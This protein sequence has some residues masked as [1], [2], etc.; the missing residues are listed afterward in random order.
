MNRDLYFTT[1]PSGVFFFIDI[2]S[3]FWVVLYLCEFTFLSVD[4]L[5]VLFSHRDKFLWWGDVS[6]SDLLM[7]V[8][9][10]VTGLLLVVA[11][12]C[13]YIILEYLSGS[14]NRIEVASFGLNH[15]INRDVY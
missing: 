15:F 5:L 14:L 4:V 7:F 9:I 12:E 10:T 6:R 1:L 11:V 13:H 3:F 2:V 8:F